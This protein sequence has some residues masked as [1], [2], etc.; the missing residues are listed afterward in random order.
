MNRQKH[1]RKRNIYIYIKDRNNM[2]SIN[3]N[4]HYAKV[5]IKFVTTDISF[6]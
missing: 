1:G 5:E 6:L 3:H 2:Y 4:I